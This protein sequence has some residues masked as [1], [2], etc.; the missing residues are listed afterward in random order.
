MD[1]QDVNKQECVRIVL[2]QDGISSAISSYAR[3]ATESRHGFDADGFERCAFHIES[4]RKL[5]TFVAAT[6]V[7]PLPGAVG[8]WTIW[9]VAIRD[10]GHYCMSARMEPSDQCTMGPVPT[11][12]S[13]RSARCNKGCASGSAPVH[14]YANFS[15]PW[16]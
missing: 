1:L 10:V 5:Y 11:V 4:Q 7:A 2:L 12:R 13:I 3:L 16:S 8:Q 14:P 6:P 15:V 9:A